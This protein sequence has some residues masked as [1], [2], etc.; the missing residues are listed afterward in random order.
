MMALQVEEEVPAAIADIHGDRRTLVAFWLLGVFNN[1]CYV[2][3]LAGATSISSS[4]VGVVYLCAVAPGIILKLSAPYW[5]HRVPYSTR[6]LAAAGLM[7]TAY[8][9]VAAADGHRGMQLLGVVGASLQGALGEASC[10]ALTSHFRSQ[11]AIT[12]WSS[13]TGFAGVAGYLWV[14]ALHTAGG[15]DFRS[16][17]LAANATVAA[18]LFAYFALLERPET[19]TRQVRELM[20][21]DEQL[22]VATMAALDTDADEEAEDDARALLPPRRSGDAAGKGLR[23]P[24]TGARMSPRERFARTLSLWPYTVPLFC[25]YFSEY[26][27]QSGAWTAIGFPAVTDAAARQRFY[28][29]ANSAYQAG[30]FVSRS[31]GTVWQAGRR[32]LWLMPVAQ[33]GWLAFFLADSVYHFWYDWGLLGPCFITG[34]LGGAT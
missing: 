29:Y 26:A 33:V 10:L 22:V 28:V 20:S 19:R 13:G 4:A 5:F 17:L 24:K 21:A 16:T 9:T 18:W 12:A 2:V 14:A 7:A 34:L 31:S 15:W 3:M 30:V 11:A 23:R 25:V 27:M 6:V 1:M 32:V 8:T